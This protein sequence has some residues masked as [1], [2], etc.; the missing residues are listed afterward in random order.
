M[1]CRRHRL[2]PTLRR[3]ARVHWRSL[4]CCTCC[5]AEGEYRRVSLYICISPYFN[6]HHPLAGELAS[7]FCCSAKRGFPRATVDPLWYRKGGCFP[8]LFEREFCKQRTMFFMQ[9]QA[10]LPVLSIGQRRH[11]LG[12]EG[13]LAT[14]TIQ[15]DS[16]YSCRHNLC[17][18]YSSMH[19]MLIG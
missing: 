13:K 12:G 8:L 1:G 17:R 3:P 18:H 16:T 19:S 10:S 4:I 5:G 15:A 14:T 2:R 9:A 7:R 11:R 6:H